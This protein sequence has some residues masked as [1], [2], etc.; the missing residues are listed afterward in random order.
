MQGIHFI[1]LESLQSSPRLELITPSDPR[2]TA[3]TM[4]KE[5]VKTPEVLGS[6]SP[7]SEQLP[8]SSSLMR[9]PGSSTTPVIMSTAHSPGGHR[10]SLRSPSREAPHGDER[11]GE[12][13]KDGK[14][15]VCCIKIHEMKTV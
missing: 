6:R 12:N 15:R 7:R 13:M 10:A 11:E 2:S 9:Q 8:V 3:S 4:P 5:T 14:Q 1:Q